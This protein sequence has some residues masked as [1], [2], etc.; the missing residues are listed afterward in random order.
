MLCPYNVVYL[1]E[2]SCKLRNG[3]FKGLIDSGV[4]A[5]TVAS[6]LDHPLPKRSESNHLVCLQAKQINYMKK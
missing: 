2:N 6:P 3:K 5:L 4:I 1:P